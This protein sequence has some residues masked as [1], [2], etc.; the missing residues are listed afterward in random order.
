MC[1]CHLPLTFYFFHVIIV[2]NSGLVSNYIGQ[3][4]SQQKKG[5]FISWEKAFK[6]RVYF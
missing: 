2:N 1:D 3:S 6:I 5:D 4:L